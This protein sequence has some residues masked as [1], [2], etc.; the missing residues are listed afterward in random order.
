MKGLGLYER[1]ITAAT[2]RGRNQLPE[3]TTATPGP[4]PADAQ[5]PRTTELPRPQVHEYRLYR[6][7]MKTTGSTDR[8]S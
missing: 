1:S 6:L 3:S 5:A 4:L 8:G 2:T 7:R